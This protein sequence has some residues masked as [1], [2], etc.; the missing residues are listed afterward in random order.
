MIELVGARDMP[1]FVFRVV[2][3]IDEDHLTRLVARIVEKLGDFIAIY[4]LQSLC[5]EFGGKL[6][7]R[8]A[9]IRPGGPIG[10]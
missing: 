8:R 7:E 1:L 4:Q 6:L 10:A 2:A 3:G 5:L 9:R